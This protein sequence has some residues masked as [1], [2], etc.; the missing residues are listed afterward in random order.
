ME[1]GLDC[2]PGSPDDFQGCVEGLV[3]KSALKNW[4]SCLD[5]E[6][7]ETHKEDKSGIQRV[8]GALSQLGISYM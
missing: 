5:N 8:E 2:S 1:F 7:D 3:Y 6:F 4:P